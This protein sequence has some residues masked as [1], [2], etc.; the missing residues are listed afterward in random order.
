M[1]KVVLDTN[2][3]IDGLRDENSSAWKVI[4]KIFSGEI[5]LYTSHPLE[6]EYRRILRREIE[7]SNYA[8]R[9]ESLLEIANKI[10]V[11]NIE[12]LVIGDPEDDKVLATALSAGATFLISEDKHLLDMDP[13]GNLRIVR[14]KEY[15]NNKEQDSSW[16]DFARMIGIK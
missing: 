13:Y 11:H 3:L 6:R 5:E 7:D 8:S 9:I 15:L 14:T 10:E 16:G 12:H 4:D 2:V 1:E